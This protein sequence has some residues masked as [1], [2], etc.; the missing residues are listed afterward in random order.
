MLLYIYRERVDIQARRSAYFHH[1][2]ACAAP[3]WLEAAR[4]Y[5]SSRRKA[6]S[7]ISRFNSCR[8]TFIQLSV[9]QLDLH[10]FRSCSMILAYEC[11]DEGL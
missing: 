10:T 11:W 6:V 2:V 8:W 3:L 5:N 9:G 7:R 1:D 4:T